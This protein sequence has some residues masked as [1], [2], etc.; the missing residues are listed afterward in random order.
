M[1][2]VFGEVDIISIFTWWPSG[3][4]IVLMCSWSEIN[5]RRLPSGVF[6]NQNIS[7]ANLTSSK[8]VLNIN[9]YYY[10]LLSV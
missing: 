2:C 10:M 3:V 8:N 4:S 7:D 9:I 5:P 1:V 6:Y